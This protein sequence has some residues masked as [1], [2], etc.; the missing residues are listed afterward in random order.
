VGRRGKIVADSAQTSPSDEDLERVAGILEGNG[1]VSDAV[2]SET[3]LRAALSIEIHEYMRQAKPVVATAIPA[4]ESF[5]NLIY[6]AEDGTSLWNKLHV[7]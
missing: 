7:P 4:V 5:R 6:V 3:M 1:C 2:P